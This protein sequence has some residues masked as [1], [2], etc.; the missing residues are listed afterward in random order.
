M[1]QLLKNGRSAI[2]TSATHRRRQEL[3]LPPLP[4]LNLD[5]L[6]TLLG[7]DDEEGQA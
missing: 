7:R 2:V 4:E 5:Q 1:G 3:G 6:H